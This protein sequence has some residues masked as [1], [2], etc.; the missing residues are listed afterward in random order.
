[1]GSVVFFATEPLFLFNSKCVSHA[2]SHAGVSRAEACPGRHVGHVFAEAL[3]SSS[4]GSKCS[5]VRHR[6]ASQSGPVVVNNPGMVIVDLESLVV[7]LV[8]GW[9]KFIPVVVVQCLSITVKEILLHGLAV[10]TF[11]VGAD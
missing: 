2:A 7:S 6:R 4:S 11:L 1:V 3:E 10:N 9:V 8:V 5:W